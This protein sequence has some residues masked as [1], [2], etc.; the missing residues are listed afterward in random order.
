MRSRSKTKDKTAAAR[1]IALNGK[2]AVVALLRREIV[3]R[4]PDIAK[5]RYVLALNESARAR[6][7][8]TP[9]GGRTL[10][11]EPQIERARQLIGQGEYLYTVVRT[12]GVNRVTPS[13][14]PP[15]Q[16]AKAPAFCPPL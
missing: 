6:P 15:A 16:S 1:G 5:L 14:A 9:S 10:L 8:R 11:K 13:R 7:V 12:L 2:T 3:R 4:T